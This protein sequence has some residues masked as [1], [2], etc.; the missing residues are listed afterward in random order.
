M[1]IF[2]FYH[3]SKVIQNM[4]WKKDWESYSDKKY[5]YYYENKILKK[6]NKK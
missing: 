5:I 4:T 6:N 1:T 2:M 3:N